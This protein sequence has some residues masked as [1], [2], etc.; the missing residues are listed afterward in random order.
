MKKRLIVLQDGYKECGSAALLSIL[1]YY[2]GNAPISKILELTSTTKEGTTFYNLKNAAKNLGLLAKAYK[3]DN[4]SYLKEINSPS[5]CQI[6]VKNY[7]HF[8][9]VY[10]VKKN[11]VEIMDP[12]KGDII[13]VLDEFL[14]RWTNN[15][16]IF[17]PKQKLINY[18][19]EKVINNIIIKLI[20][21]NKKLYLIVILISL[22]YTLTTCIYSY[23]MKLSI[24]KVIE[25]SISNL[26]LITIIFTSVI[27][28]KNLSNYLRNNLLVFINEKMD[29]SI[30]NEIYQKI[31]LLPY[32]YFYNHNTGDIIA[33]ITD[34][35]KI[36][37]IINK[38]TITL[39]L[40]GF[41]FIT[42]SFILLSINSLLFKVLIVNI[43][44][45]LIIL[46]IFRPITK[47]YTIKI[48]E[49]NAILSTFLVETISSFE[50]IKG[51]SLEP[52][53]T[54]KL[55]KL[56]INN[57]INKSKFIKLL[58]LQTFLKDITKS[59]CM[60]LI[61]YLGIKEV[62]NQNLT[63]TNFIT[64]NAVL[65]YFLDPIRNI[66]DLNEDYFYLKNAIKRVNSMFVTKSINLKEKD[67]L[68][69]NGNINIK[70]LTY[71][72][73]NINPV[74]N[75]I[76]LTISNNEK[77]LIMGPS[78]SGKSTLLKTLMKYYQIKRNVI[79]INDIDINDISQNTIKNNIIYISQNELIYTDT[80]RNN[81][82]LNR[83]VDE[84]KFLNIC[85]ICQVD[86]VVEN[87]FLGYATVL[88][89]N[90]HNLSGGQRQRIVL[91]RSLI[92]DANILLIDEGLNQL[93][94]NL[95][96]KIL[97]ELFKLNKTIIV[98]S[99]RIDNM[100]LYNKVVK[101]KN[102]EIDTILERS[103]N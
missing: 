68:I 28:I 22:I 51:I 87:L 78:G 38:I 12:A 5:I 48:Q 67:N 96:R 4:I 89:E 9:V 25:G 76:N 20:D 86:K 56:A 19:E 84:T 10:K 80:I 37:D 98:V 13:M 27:I 6:K 95:E 30:L 42:S 2:G 53:M 70:N 66:I 79:T 61:M 29:F 82:C 39:I 36:K 97:K 101:I 33:R 90:G 8:V 75:N 59:I 50:T 15:V 11:Y 99:H 26:K 14:K 57:I 21:N 100:D 46:M 41:I 7:L 55:E 35:S 63:L 69:I 16:M 32:N 47:D 43:I 44:V 31:L 54:T 73:N 74:L 64:F 92:N 81:I 102:N 60:I 62:L 40:D 18:K 1:R 3:L 34:S 58:H 65:I 71:S 94:I 103:F 77:I 88:E 17:E 49:D 24:D 52:I 83:Q 85:K 72:F 93:D 23:Y 45:Y 91:A